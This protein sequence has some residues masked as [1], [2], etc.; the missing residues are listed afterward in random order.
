MDASGTVIPVVLY[1]YKLKDSTLTINTCD[2][3]GTSEKE[4]F[5]GKK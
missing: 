3:D 1:T 2:D 5:V 4:F